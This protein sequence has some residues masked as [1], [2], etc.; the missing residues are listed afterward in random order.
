VV[1]LAMNARDAMPGGGKL[2]LS[3]AA[4]RLERDG[5]T[6]PDEYAG[7]FVQLTVADSGS[8][9]PP[10]IV[11]HVFEPFFTTKDAG[12][13][14]GLGLATT[15][16]IV[17]QH[18]GWIRVA[19]QLGAGTRF[20]VFLPASTAAPV[21]AT[22][23]PAVAAGGVET[24]LVVEDEPGVRRVAVEGL[25]RKGY[26]VLSA[27]SGVEA[28]RVWEARGPEIDL[29]FTDLVM[30][31]GIGGQQLAAQL[32]QHRPDLPVIYTSGY[33]REFVD[34]SGDPLREG[35]NFLQKPYTL[36]RLAET[37]RSFLDRA[38]AAGR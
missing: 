23:G 20:D 32:R 33:S 31:E 12:K 25:T 37:V 26:R 10:D 34:G 19:S 2:T 28:L 38:R 3:T 4:V 15:H 9:I 1:N 7:P 29:L 6:G 24:I 35:V 16:G 13:G 22:I 11:P 36:S 21:V 14:S 17:Q 27:G 18:R 5:L 30:P 8:G